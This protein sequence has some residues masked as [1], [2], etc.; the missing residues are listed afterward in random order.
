MRM[1]IFVCAIF[2]L[3][4]VVNYSYAKIDPD[5]I[6]GI[7]LLD[8]GK[9]D[10][11]EDASENGREGTITQGQ[12]EEGQFDSALEIK[13]GGTVTIPLGKGIIEDKVTF[14]LW[15][16]FTDIGGSR[17]ISLYGIRV[18]IAMSLT[19]TVEISCVAGRILGMS[20]AV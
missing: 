5:R 9:G 19:K 10:V 17:T 4:F 13:K 3:G 20:P 7:W 16:Q 2:L 6:V 1:T 8:E 15:L 18:T 11:A 14:T 12:W